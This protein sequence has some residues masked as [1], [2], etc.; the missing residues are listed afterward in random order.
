MSSKR[1]KQLYTDFQKALQRLEEALA[2][3][4]TEAAGTVLDGTIQRFE[5]T[6]ELAWKLAKNILNYQGIEAAN[7]RDV[8]KEAFQQGLIKDGD[9]WIAMLEDRNRTSHVYDEE[10]V[11]RIYDNIK[12]RYHL[13]L[14]EF[15]KAADGF[16]RN[17]S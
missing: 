1:I 14:E 8:I 15:L 6:F 7:P 13:Q 4:P 10:E 5:F 9:G 3:D 11:R 17:L 16:V 12:G 2:Q